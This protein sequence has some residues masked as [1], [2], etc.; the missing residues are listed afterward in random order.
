MKKHFYLVAALF[1]GLTMTT[2][3]CDDDDDDV[4]AQ[5]TTAADIDYTS[6]TAASWNNYAKNVAALLKQDSQTLYDS[7]ATSYDGG[8]AFATTFKNHDGGDYTSA[9]NCIEEILDGCATIADEVGNAKI[10]DP[11]NLY[12]DGKTTEALYAVESWYS[13]HSRDDYS[14]NVLS[15]RNSYYGSTDNKTVAENSIAAV[16]KAVDADLDKK[17]VDV[18]NAAYDAIQAIPQPFRNNINSVE[19]Q[20]AM[21]AC[22]ELEGVF[23]DDLKMFFNSNEIDEA[24]LDAVVE[25][26]VDNVVLPTYKSLAERN[27]TLYNAVVALGNNPSNEAFQTA[28]DAW[29]ASREPWEKSEAFLFGPVD[30]LGLDPNMDSWP[31]DQEAIVSILKSNKFDDLNWG[32]GDSDEAVEA[33]QSVRGFHTLEFLL[34]KDGKART[35]K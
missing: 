32:D 16:V 5:E 26:Y 18:I 14:N 15:I 7:W 9:I 23:S 35:V 2:T 1:M 4:D 10:G 17:V 34:F 19:T 21:T 11:Y 8:E 3:A 33:A 28:C 12:N 6:E 25:N 27:V 24:K 22:A 20:K 30:A 31:L 13:W 29:L